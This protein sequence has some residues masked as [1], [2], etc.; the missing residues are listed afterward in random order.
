MIQYFTNDNFKVLAELYDDK[1]GKGTVHMTQQEVADKVGLCRVT[2]N[3]I[4]GELKELGYI[5]TDGVHMGRY[6][7]TE[8]A[9]NVVEK[10]RNIEE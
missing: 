3:R 8:P 4:M 5:Q 10:I 6:I 7:L 2:V 9:L 1:D